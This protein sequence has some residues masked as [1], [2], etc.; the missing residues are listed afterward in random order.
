MYSIYLNSVL[1][2]KYVYQLHK[3]RNAEK[4]YFYS[5]FE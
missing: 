4:Y 2:Q 1:V 5:N 3:N